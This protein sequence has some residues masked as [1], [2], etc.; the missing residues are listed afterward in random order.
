MDYSENN[1]EIYRLGK[2][3][4]MNKRK[5]IYDTHT[6]HKKDVIYYKE[7]KCP[8]RLE[9][10]VR[11]MLYDHRYKDKKDFF[12]C[13]L[14]K[15]KNAFKKCLESMDCVDQNGGSIFNNK[16]MIK[17]I[18]DKNKINKKLN[19]AIKKLSI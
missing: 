6:L 18:R 10:C 19:E 2:T 1:T 14:A 11:S 5:K 9:T 16:K 8:L 15:I 13:S 17:L 12:I 4:N 3:G 7:T